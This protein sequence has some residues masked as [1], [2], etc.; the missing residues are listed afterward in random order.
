MGRAGDARGSVSPHPT[1]DSLSLPRLLTPD[2]TCQILR[3]SI[4]R[5][6]ALKDSGLLPAYRVGRSLRFSAADIV[7]MLENS[8]EESSW[9]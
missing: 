2:E 6:Y 3:V 5:L 7:A 1:G 4:R 8:R 9:W